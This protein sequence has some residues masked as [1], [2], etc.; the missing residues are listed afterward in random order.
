MVKISP[1]ILSAD[2]TNLGWALN[3]AY[4][5]GADYVH[6]DI[7]D[8]H[9]V[10]NLTIGPSVCADLAAHTKL[11]LDIHLMVEEPDRFIT[12]LVAQLQKRL[13]GKEIG[14]EDIAELQPQRI[15]QIFASIELRDLGLALKGARQGVLEKVLD[16]ITKDDAAKLVEQMGNLGTIK[17]DEITDAKKRITEHIKKG[18]DINPVKYLTVHQ[19]TETHLDR[20]LNHIRSL[21]FSPGVSINPA[22]PVGT[23]EHVL[24]LCDL[25]LVMS[26]NPGFGGQEFIPYTLDKVRQLRTMITDRHLQTAIEIDGGIKPDNAGYASRAGCDILVAGAAVF[27]DKATPAE[28]IKAIQ[29]ACKQ[30]V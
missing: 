21:G 30:M 11:P 13:L 24:H 18:R 5:G 23:I 12:L 4:E 8:L 10:P 16:S 19:E 17:R 22:T 14:F 9:F 6:I 27:N 20:M 29:D 1:S 7:M 26:V 28:N 25:V 2:Q 15:K 3:A